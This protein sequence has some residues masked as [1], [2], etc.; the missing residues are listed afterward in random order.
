[1]FCLYHVMVVNENNC[2]TGD[3]GFQSSVKSMSGQGG[4]IILFGN[5]RGQQR[6]P[7]IKIPPHQIASKR[8]IIW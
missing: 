2:I 8:W 5:K 3:A 6:H 4:N 7:A 1:M